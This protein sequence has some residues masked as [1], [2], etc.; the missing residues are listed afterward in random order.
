MCRVSLAVKQEQA[1]NRLTIKLEASNFWA[2]LLSELKAVAN[3]L[4][5]PI[6]GRFHH[7][8]F[9]MS[10]SED[11]CQLRVWFLG[12]GSAHRDSYVDVRFRPDSHAIS[13]VSTLS[14]EKVSLVMCVVDGRIRAASQKHPEPLDAEGVAELIARPLVRHARSGALICA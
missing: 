4:V 5:Q 11:H 12:D 3:G 6:T 2:D 9:D 8:N 7:S 14:S 13:Y 1:I 10:R